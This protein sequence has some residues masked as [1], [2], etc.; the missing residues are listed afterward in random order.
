MMF[1]YFCRAITKTVVS[2]ELRAEI[3][4]N[5]KVMCLKSNT[6]P[7]PLGFHVAQDDDPV[8]LHTTL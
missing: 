1:F 4:E 8:V 7:L 6:V 2:S 3:E 5:Q